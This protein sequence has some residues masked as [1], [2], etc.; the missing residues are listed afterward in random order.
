MSET[1]NNELTAGKQSKEPRSHQKLKLLYLA[2]ILLNNTDANHDI[3]LDEILNKLHAYDVTAAR[4]SLYD[5]IAQLN[6]FGIKTQK[7]QYGRTVHY[8]VIGRAFELAELKLLVD[9]V[10]AAKFITEEKSNELIK[11]LESLTSRQ[12]AATLQRQVYVAGR[13]KT[14]NSDIMKECFAYKPIWVVLRVLAVI[15]VWLTYLGVG[16]DGVG[17]IGMIPGGGQGG[18][19]LY[20]LLTPLVIIFVIAALL[21]PLLLDFGLLEFVG[22]LLTKVMRPLF[23]VPGRA[24]VDCLT[25]WTGDGTLG[26]MLTCNPYEGGYYSAKEASIIATLFSAVSITFTL[27]VLDTVGMLDKFGIY[28]LIVCFVGIVCAIVCP[29]LYPLRK[30]PNT[31]LVEGKAAPDTLPE[32]YK[33]NVEYGMDLAMKR[34]A[35]HKGIGEFFK[36]G[37]KNAC[38]M[39]FGV[40]PSVMAIGTVALILANYTPIFEWLGIPFRPLLQLL[41]VPEA[42]AVAS[43]MIVGFTDMLTPAILIAECTSEMARFIVAVV[44]VT[45]VLY[46]SEVGGLILGSKLPLNIWELFVIFLERTIIS[47]LIV[48]PIAHLLF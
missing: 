36:S 21:L 42:D 35:E 31:Y 9:S 38:S 34:V 43:T 41:Q 47:L 23:K 24:A 8:K 7:T 20:D 37:A 2:K 1:E 17:L 33:S 22:A 32:G 11:K 15:F 5:D 3:T 6:D 19:V 27:V 44:S 12:E 40:L 46:L 14:M 45:Q 39:W 26:A 10:A 18:F 13:V 29:Y 28:Y 25:S 30:K 48:C 4:K 16:E